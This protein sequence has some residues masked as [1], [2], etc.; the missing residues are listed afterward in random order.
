LCGLVNR[1]LYGDA[2]SLKLLSLSGQCRVIRITR[3]SRF[4]IMISKL[5]PFMFFSI[6]INRLPGRTAIGKAVLGS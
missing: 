6:I 1:E 5:E 3:R 2:G 4:T